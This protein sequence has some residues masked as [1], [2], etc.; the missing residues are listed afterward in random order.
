[1]ATQ[2]ILDSLDKM[3][4]SRKQAL[5]SDAD[6]I[7]SNGETQEILRKASKQLGHLQSYSNHHLIHS[8]QSRIGAHI[9]LLDRI[10]ND[11]AS[12]AERISSLQSRMSRNY[13]Q[14]YSAAMQTID[15]NGTAD[16]DNK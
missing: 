14:Q 4:V 13:P 6:G 1:M 2:Y 9:A 7:D 3:D 12:V 11:M 15:S 8:L 10:R 5:N 16:D